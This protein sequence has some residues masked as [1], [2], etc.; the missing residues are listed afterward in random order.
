M[1]D[2]PKSKIVHINTD[3]YG[4]APD[5]ATTI[6]YNSQALDEHYCNAERCYH[7]NFPIIIDA[8]RAHGIDTVDVAFYGSGDSGSIDS[9]DLTPHPEPMPQIAVY[10][11]YSEFNHELNR[12]VTYEVVK[13]MSLTDAIEGLVYDRLDMTESGWEINEGG[14]GHFK[15][16]VANNAFEFHLYINAIEQVTYESDDDP[17]NEYLTTLANPASKE[18][19]L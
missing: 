7:L 15:L 10:V 12:Y 11:M 8:L 6:S 9:V 19:T 17:L 1:T 4:V 14:G 16:D 3:P 2:K 13:P 5:I 18:D